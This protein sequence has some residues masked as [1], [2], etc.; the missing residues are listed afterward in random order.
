[1]TQLKNMRKILIV[2]RN[3]RAHMIMPNTGK[4]LYIKL[5]ATYFFVLF[6]LDIQILSS[7]CIDYFFDHVIGST[8]KIMIIAGVLILCNH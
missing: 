1:M 5:L 6:T 8:I 2:V 7:K 4:L 3:A